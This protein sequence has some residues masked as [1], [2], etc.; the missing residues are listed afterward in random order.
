MS[1]ED[2]D[3]AHTRWPGWRPPRRPPFVRAYLRGLQDN[4]RLR[5]PCPSCKAK[6]YEH[7]VEW[8]A[9]IDPDTGERTGYYPVEKPNP[10]TK[11]PRMEQR[12]CR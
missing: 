10:C 5:Y 4:S 3:R 9:L 7:C 6:R 12:S 11:R 1:R 8:R 2:A